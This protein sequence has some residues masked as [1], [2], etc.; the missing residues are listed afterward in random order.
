MDR[1]Y[2]IGITNDELTQSDNELIQTN[3]ELH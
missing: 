3:D 2:Q 1:V